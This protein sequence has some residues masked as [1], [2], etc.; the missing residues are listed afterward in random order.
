MP[1]LESFIKFVKKTVRN[2]EK[3]NISLFSEHGVYD[4]SSFSA[5]SSVTSLF[6]EQQH[7]LPVHCTLKIN[8]V[9]LKF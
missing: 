7:T 8:P 3:T 9:L 5:S 1:L 2:M 4:Y 6:K